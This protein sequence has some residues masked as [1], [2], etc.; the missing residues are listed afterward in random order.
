MNS[1]KI[2]NEFEDYLTLKDE[3]EDLSNWK[4]II[5]LEKPSSADLDWYSTR[6]FEVFLD[7]LDIGQPSI[8]SSAKST[9]DTCTKSSNQNLLPSKKTITNDADKINI[10]SEDMGKNQVVDTSTKTNR[11]SRTQAA[12]TILSAEALKILSELPDLSHISSTRS[13]IFPNFAR[14]KE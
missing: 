4:R 6:T 7:A 10:N 14:S 12:E 13:F 11:S 1:P 8:N 3:D 2:I 5:E 9:T